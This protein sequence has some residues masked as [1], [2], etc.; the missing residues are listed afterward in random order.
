MSKNYKMGIVLSILIL[1]FSASLLWFKI[2]LN[3][4]I[5]F[6]DSLARD[7]FE[8]NGRWSD[9]RITPA[10]A[11]FPDMILYFFAYKVLPN[12]HSR[13]F[14]VSVLQ[15]F[16][17]ALTVTW[18]SKQ[19]YPK[20]SDAA[21]AVLLLLVAFTTLVAPQSGSGM[22]LYFYTAD[23]HFAALVVSMICLGLAIRFYIRPSITTAGLLI[24]AGVIAMA[25]TAI[26]LINFLVPAIILTLLILIVAIHSPRQHGIYFSRMCWILCIFVVSFLLSLKLEEMLTYNSAL[27]SRYSTKFEPAAISNSLDLFFQSTINAFSFQNKLTFIFSVLI[28]ASLLFL[29]YRFFR[30]ITFGDNGVFIKLGTNDQ[31]TDDN[32]RIVLC[33]AF[34]FTVIPIN[35]FGSI[36]S[37]GI[38]DIFAY[39]Y[40]SFP[41]ALMLILTVIIVDKISSFSSSQRKFCF[42]LMCLTLIVLSV[43]AFSIRSPIASPA[44]SISRCLIEIEKHGFNL[45]EGIADYW[46]ARA[47]SEYLPNRNWI[48]ATTNDLNPFFWMSSV[49]PI[50]RPNDYQYKYNFVILNTI[51]S[52][53]PSEYNSLTVGKLLPPPNRVHKCVDAKAEIWLYDD[54]KLNTTLEGPF[55]RFLW[56]R[57][58]GN[59]YQVDGAILPGATGNVVGLARRAEASKDKAGFLSFGPY[60]NLEE[61]KYVVLVNYSTTGPAGSTIGYVDM[62][63]FIGAPET[64]LLYKKI[65]KANT[66]GNLTA[67]V[68]VPADGISKFEVRTWFSGV[69]SML[70]KSLKIS[71][72][73]DN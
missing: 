23:N 73:K 39:R 1:A 70:V 53:E 7:L 62:G 54:D 71:K 14:F 33:Y 63:Q 52:R 51:N 49:N 15:V 30:G 34:L 5:L 44:L 66:A 72:E 24:L 55:N 35:I 13:I 27:E 48:L 3:S 8:Q 61:G 32:W 31:V 22:W 25:S 68:K 4:D 36:L 10:P 19:I 18:T 40:L 9:W 26:Y 56:F 59:I 69:G 29:V 6:L 37:G 43:R 11:Y 50:R 16:I 64:K 38:V 42:I 2:S 58:W 28:L 17:L 12:A 65:V 60:I 20:I 41:I 67:L 46:N 45:K 47:V 57:K 21:L